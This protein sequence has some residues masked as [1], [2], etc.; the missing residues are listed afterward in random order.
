MSVLYKG[1]CSLYTCV[2]SFLELG[3]HIWER[4]DTARALLQ[5]GCPSDRLED[6]R[7][8]TVLLKNQR[9]TF[10]PKEQR[11][12]RQQGQ[13]T[14]LQP[15]TVLLNLRPGWWKNMYKQPFLLRFFFYYNSYYYFIFHIQIFVSSSSQG[16]A[17][18]TPKSFYCNYSEI[19]FQTS[20]Q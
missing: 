15:Q 12:Q 3:Q 18:R 20:A 8:S 19:F 6:P 11:R 13:V 4:C 5:R 16:C 10:N 2:K 14:Q 9:I 17:K 1:L 7:G